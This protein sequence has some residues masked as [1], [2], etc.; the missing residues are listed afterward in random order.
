MTPRPPPPVPAVTTAPPCKYFAG[1][2]RRS[3]LGRPNS[4]SREGVIGRGAGR[5]PRPRI[6]FPLPHPGVW[7]RGSDLRKPKEIP[8]LEARKVVSVVHRGFQ[9]P[10]LRTDDLE[11]ETPDDRPC[12]HRALG[13]A[14][15]VCVISG[16]DGGPPSPS[17]PAL[18][19]SP[20]PPSPTPLTRTKTHS[21]RPSSGTSGPTRSACSVKGPSAGSG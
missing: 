15:S 10:S 9:R 13:P 12:S 16:W 19:V 8:F 6:V 7:S 21:S 5:D 14:L 20:W 1:V 18:G 11:R 4:S 17:D 2:F 3:R